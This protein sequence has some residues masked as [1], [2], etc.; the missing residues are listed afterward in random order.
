MAIVDQISRLTSAANKIKTKTAAL[1]LKKKNSNE[2]ISA[3]DKLDVQADAIDA[4]VVYTPDTI[5]LSD[6]S[7]TIPCGGKFVNDDIVVPAANVYR[8]GSSEPTSSTPGNDGD[9]YLVTQ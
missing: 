5:S 7:Q 2:T 6:Q 3:T 4:I 9:L 1:G 8:T